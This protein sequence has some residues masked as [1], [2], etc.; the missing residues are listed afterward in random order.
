MRGLLIKISYL[1]SIQNERSLCLNKP[2][3]PPRK[4]PCVALP[5]S[6]INTSLKFLLAVLV[7]RSQPSK[8][9]PQPLP[10]TTSIKSVLNPKKNKKLSKNPPNK[11]K[12]PKLKTTKNPSTTPPRNPLVKFF[13]LPARS[14]RLVVISATPGANSVRSAGQ[15]VKLLGS[16]PSQYSSTAQP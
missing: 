6:T 7:Q 4:T 8:I 11:P 5:V 2:K 3:K 10:K 14:W 13:C 12:R 15:I 1:R 9:Q 16:S